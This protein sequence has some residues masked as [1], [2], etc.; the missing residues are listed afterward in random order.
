MKYCNYF[1]KK[2]EIDF[3]QHNYLLI[4]SITELLI[5]YQQKWDPL[6]VTKNKHTG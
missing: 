6:L 1:I 4:Q 2:Y 3:I 5:R